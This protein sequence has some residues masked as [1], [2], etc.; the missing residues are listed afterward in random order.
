MLTLVLLIAAAGIHYGIKTFDE[1]GPLAADTSVVIPKGSGVRDV[2][3]RLVQAGAIESQNVFMAGVQLSGNRGKMQAGEYEFPRQASMRQIMAMIATGQVVEHT[4]TI[5]EGLTSLQIVERLQQEDLLTGAIRNVPPEGTLLPET[6][7]VVR[8][9]TREQLIAR[10]TQ[11]QQ[12]LLDEVWKRRNPEVPVK[13]PQELVTLASIVEKETGVASERPHVASVFVNRLLKKMRIQSDPTII[14]GLVGGKGTLGRPI[15]KSEILRPTPYNTY[16]IPALPPGPI[17]NPGRA[18]MEA[19]A[20][21]L[22][23]NDLYFVADG[24][25]GHAF[26]PSYAEHRKNVAR[27]RQIDRAGETDRAPP[28]AVPAEALAPIGTPP[29]R[30]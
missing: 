29:A 8:G 16:T 13:S 7:Q 5:P 14:Y 18:S 15:L 10:M 27:W 6:Y 9:T 12:K 24:T 19:V 21:P 23:T 3:E 25:G 17:A 22:D 28:D 4:I 26:A 20:N 2:A 30:R 11:A 1:P